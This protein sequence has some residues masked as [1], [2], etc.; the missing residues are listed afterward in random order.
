MLLLT[1]YLQARK[2][3]AA[4]QKKIEALSAAGGLADGAVGALRKQNAEL[5]AAL[6]ERDAAD[7]AAQEQLAALQVG[8][9]WG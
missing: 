7:K 6:A 9:W 5:L 4:Q 2:E 8:G 1:K 3:C